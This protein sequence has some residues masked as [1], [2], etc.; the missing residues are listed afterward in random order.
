[1]TIYIILNGHYGQKVLIS[2]EF[3]ASTKINE[4]ILACRGHKVG[5]EPNDYKKSSFKDREE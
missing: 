2:I 1:M 4:G 3:S 5:K